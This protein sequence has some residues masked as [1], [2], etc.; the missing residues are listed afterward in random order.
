MNGDLSHSIQAD[1]IMKDP[2]LGKRKAWAISR[3]RSYRKAMRK[4]NASFYL[5]AGRCFGRACL[6]QE[7]W[8]EARLK[9]WEQW[10]GDVSHFP[11]TDGSISPHTPLEERYSEPTEERKST[12]WSAT[13]C[14]LMFLSSLCQKILMAKAKC[15]KRVLV[16]IIYGF[17]N[18]HYTSPPLFFPKLK[19]TVYL[20][21]HLCPVLPSLSIPFS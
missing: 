13:K 12:M 15:S 7:V 9:G 19:R 6:W 4:I 8:D 16:N 3:W 21:S 5:Q 17:I 18:L 10:L 1:A 20:A 2:R 11:S 14:P